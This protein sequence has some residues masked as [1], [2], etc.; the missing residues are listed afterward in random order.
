MEKIFECW[1]NVGAPVSSALRTLGSFSF[2][3][4]C[5][6]AYLFD[7]LKEKRYLQLKGHSV[8]AYVKPSRCSQ[9]FVK[10]ILQLLN[11]L[12]KYWPLFLS[13]LVVVASLRIENY[14][15]DS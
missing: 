3:L 4:H 1:V 13:L 10:L 14:Q 8:G 2:E 12:L 15:F 6:T 11:Q 7:A 9:N 5:V